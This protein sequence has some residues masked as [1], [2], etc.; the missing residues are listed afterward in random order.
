MSEEGLRMAIGAWVLALGASV[1]SFLNVVIARVPAGESIVRPRSRCP[2]CLSQIAWYD[3]L[4]VVSWIA[5]RGRCR[6]C[7]TAISPRYLLVELL[8]AAA[9]WLAWQRHGLSLAGLAEL[10][11]VEL[12]VA[13]AFIDLATWLLP[14][15][16]TWPLLATGVLASALGLSA[17]ATF[18]SSA[19]GA[20]TGFAGFA[21]VAWV[22]KLAA[23]KEA[24]GFGDV[25]LLSGLGAWLGVGA[26]LPVVLLSSVQGSVYGVAML[27]LGRGEPGPP[28]GRQQEAPE[29]AGEGP[30]PT[31]EDAE[32]CGEGSAGEA[33]GGEVDDWVPPR[34]AVPFGPFLVAGGLEWLYLSGWLASHLPGL[35]VFR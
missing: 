18:R 24:L 8:G 12:L 21:L 26:L 13:L 19:L 4:P 11:F 1:G 31:S 7:G 33:S 10:A 29:G 30:A 20:A 14:H 9:A 34:N 5:L 3:N 6:R 23:K 27:V 32:G 35:R 16:L 17:A 22:G 15:A 2:R 28:A 25:W